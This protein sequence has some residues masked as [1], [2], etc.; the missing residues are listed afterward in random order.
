MRRS[1]RT[2][3]GKPVGPTPVASGKT[4]RSEKVEVDIERERKILTIKRLFAGYR[5]ATATLVRM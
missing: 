3:V 4:T 5:R 2:K 1:D